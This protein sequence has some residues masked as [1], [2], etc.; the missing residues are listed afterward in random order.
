MSQATELVFNRCIVIV[1]EIFA[2]SMPSVAAEQRCHTPDQAFTNHWVRSTYS[3]SCSSYW[4]TVGPT[5][6]VRIDFEA[7][8]ASNAT[9]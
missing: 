5:S 7:Q 6:K 9:V 1:R 4:C 3:Q 8:K 2:G